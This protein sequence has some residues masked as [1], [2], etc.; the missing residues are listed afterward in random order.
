[1]KQPNCIIFS[2][3]N[4]AS[5]WS[6]VSRYRVISGPYF[7]AFRLNTERYEVSIR[8]QSECRKI[9]TRNNSVFGHFLRGEWNNYCISECIAH[10]KY[11]NIPSLKFSTN[12]INDWLTL[13]WRRSLSYG[14][15]SIDLQSRNDSLCWSRKP[16][17]WKSDATYEDWAFFKIS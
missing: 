6:Q 17:T 15:Q 14:N 2:L 8:I 7:P 5:S 11:R 4:T 3:I 12:S 9:R 16:K 13:S 1:M 10:G